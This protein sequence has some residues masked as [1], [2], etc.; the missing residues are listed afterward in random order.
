MTENLIKVPLAKGCYLLLLPAEYD[1]GVRRGKARR[2][3][4]QFEQ[5]MARQQQLRAGGTPGALD[6]TGKQDLHPKS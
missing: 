4:E 6:G 2:R 1:N 5:R 3:R